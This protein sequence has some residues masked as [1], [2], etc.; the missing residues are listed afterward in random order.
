M[1]QKFRIDSRE[2]PKWPLDIK[3]AEPVKIVI[4]E[5]HDPQKEAIIVFNPPLLVSSI[6]VLAV[7]KM[8]KSDV[9]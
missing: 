1:E 7:P 9:L 6:Q 8:E 3:S 2:T 5:I 4:E